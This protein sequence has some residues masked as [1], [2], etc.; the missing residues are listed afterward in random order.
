MAR[1]RSGSCVKS[2]IQM[3]IFGEQFT[4]KS[5]LALQ[6]AYMKNE[7][8]SPFKV[9]YLDA[10][11]GSIDDYLPELEKN[12]I[13]LQNIYIV[14]TQSLAETEQYIRKARDKEDFYVLDDD[15]NETDEIVKDADGK[16][17]RPDAIVVDGT[18]VLNMTTKE[19][20]IDFSK[21]RAAVKA[22]KAGL[23]GD[24]RFVKVEGSGMELK[25]Y[26]TVNFKGQNLILDLTGSGLH[27][28]ATA[29]ETDE[30]QTKEINGTKETVVTGRKIPD[31]FKGMEHNAK[32]VIRLYRDSDDYK[33]V[34]AFV[35]KDRTKAHKA[36]EIID[37]PQLTDWQVVID[38]TAKNKDYTIN[39]D[40]HS[41]IETEKKIYEQENAVTL[42]TDVKPDISKDKTIEIK[43]NINSILKKL[44]PPEKTKA[45]NKLKENNLPISFSKENDVE[46]LNKV[47]EAVKSFDK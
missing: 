26:Q 40:I 5:T 23:V 20:L 47:Y 6:F 14:Y 42:D 10:E 11:N 22:T 4:G 27:Y 36:G 43:H 34:K 24:E 19:G 29:R 15:G 37:D 33:T 30:K 28:V 44:S 17:F 45:K 31:G 18:T 46:V 39:N 13:N 12:G 7:D 32:T 25:D 3:V 2:K 1:A 8:G 38:K 9:L 21:K 16:S 35:E 41:A